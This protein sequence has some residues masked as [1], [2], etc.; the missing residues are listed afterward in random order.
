MNL[1]FIENLH[2]LNIQ[3]AILGANSNNIY[4]YI[5]HFSAQS[6]K[7][8]STLKKNFLYFRK[9]NFLALIFLY[10]LIFWGMETPKKVF[11]YHETKTLKS[12]LYFEK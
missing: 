10:F 11:I 9:W 3:V 2:L 4:G 5:V 7:K 8:K 1:Q 12:L 6:G